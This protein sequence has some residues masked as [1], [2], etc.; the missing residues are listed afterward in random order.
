MKKAAKPLT[1]T[2]P[3]LSPDDQRDLEKLARVGCVALNQDVPLEQ[4][5]QNTHRA[6]ELIAKLKPQIEN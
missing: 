6:L 2:P 1:E 3:A 5:F 4:V